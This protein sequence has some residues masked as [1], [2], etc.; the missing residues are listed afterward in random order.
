MDL[1]V[2]LIFDRNPKQK[3]VYQIV[4]SNRYFKEKE[5]ALAAVNGNENDLQ[6]HKREDYVEGAKPKAPAKTTA[7]KPAV[8]IPEGNPQKSWKVAEIKAWMD[9]EKVKY[10]TKD[11]EAA[12]LT[13]VAE[14]LKGK[15]DNP[16]Q[17]Q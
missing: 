9:R 2:K 7:K 14:H 13:K 17:D 3:E 4:G 8:V 10:T 11:N 12:L 5:N 6:T 16:E 1:R 15:D